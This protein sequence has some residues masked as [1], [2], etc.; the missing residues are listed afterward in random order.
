MMQS[1]TRRLLCTIAVVAT[2]A[3][4]VEQLWFI[5]AVVATTVVVVQLPWFIIVV[6][7][8]DT[9]AVAPPLFITHVA[10]TTGEMHPLIRILRNHPP[11]SLVIQPLVSIC[12][13][14]KAINAAGG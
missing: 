12:A 14:Q 13:L 9:A 4:V 7:D 8:T 6:E 3:A 11:L 5:I 2:M 1:G 10:A